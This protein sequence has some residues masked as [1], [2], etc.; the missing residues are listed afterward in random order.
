MDLPRAGLFGPTFAPSATEP[1]PLPVSIAA[2]WS[3]NVLVSA[4]G[5]IFSWG[6]RAPF[7]M[8]LKVTSWYRWSPWIVQ[9]IQSRRRGLATMNGAEPLRPQ[10]MPGWGWEQGDPLIQ[11]GEERLF[12]V[13]ATCGSDFLAVLSSQGQ[14]YTWGQSHARTHHAQ[15]TQ[16]A[17]SVVVLTCP[18]FAGCLRVLMCEA[19]TSTVNWVNRVI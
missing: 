4:G 1:Q 18:L 6:W 3:E 13:N 14:V 2:G 7:R 8:L 12:A 15:V 17:L 19:T 16:F 9:R 10:R 5:S 11:E